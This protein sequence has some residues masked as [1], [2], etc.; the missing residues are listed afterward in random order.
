MEPQKT[1]R[2]RIEALAKT[3]AYK[4]LEATWK[5]AQEH[6]HDQEALRAAIEAYNSVVK[7]FFH[8]IQFYCEATIRP[9][10]KAGPLRDIETEVSLRN[11]VKEALE[12]AKDKLPIFA[13]IYQGIK[14]AQSTK[15]A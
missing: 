15:N 4:R 11:I 7:L 10:S 6:P 9:S 13:T 3:F 1:L 12:L 8:Q 14:A 2:E 5:H